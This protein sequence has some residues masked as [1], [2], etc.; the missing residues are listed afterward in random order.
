MERG[1]DDVWPMGRQNHAAI[2]LGY[3]E[4]H[5]QLLVTGG[6]YA[7]ALNDTWLL[8]LKEKIWKEVNKL[9]EYGY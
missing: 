1:H 4:D 6:W 7:A 5:P 3:G 2:C 9:S 8:D